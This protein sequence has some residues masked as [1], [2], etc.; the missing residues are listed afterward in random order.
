MINRNDDGFEIE[1]EGAD[2]VRGQRARFDATQ[3]TPWLEDLGGTEWL[4]LAIRDVV[5]EWRGGKL[6]QTITRTP[7][8]ASA[9]CRPVKRRRA[10]RPMGREPVR[11]EAAAI[12]TAAHCLFA[13]SE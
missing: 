9:R 11:G 2:I 13:Q 3:Q 7:A 1:S 4:V 6:V 8:T 10:A 5:Q 12:P